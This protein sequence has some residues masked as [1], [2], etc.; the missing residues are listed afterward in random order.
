MTIA[1]DG[2]EFIPIG[3]GIFQSKET[4]RRYKAKIHLIDNGLAFPNKASKDDENSIILSRFAF[5]IWGNKIP[6]RILDEI[7][8]LKYNSFQKKLSK[9]IDGDSLNLFN[10]RTD[11]LWRGETKMRRYRIIKKSRNVRENR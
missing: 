3:D 7:K 8:K 2:E 1:I 10:E 5:A 6:Q 9:I 4:G 11:Y